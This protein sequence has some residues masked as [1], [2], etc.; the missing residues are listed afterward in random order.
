MPSATLLDQSVRACARNFRGKAQWF[1][2]F[3]PVTKKR[4]VIQDVGDLPYETVRPILIKLEKASQL[5]RTSLLIVPSTFVLTTTQRDI[6]MASPQIIGHDNEIWMEFIKRDIDGWEGKNLDPGSPPNWYKLYENLQIECQKQM[7]D[8]TAALKAALQGIKSE[9]LNHRS[10]QVAASTVPPLP[11]MGGMKLIK[12]PRKKRIVLVDD[13]PKNELMIGSRTKAVTGK[14]VIDKARR[15]AKVQTLLRDPTTLAVPTHKLDNTLSVVRQAP[16]SLLYGYQHPLVPEPLDPT[17]KPTPVFVPKR[18]RVEPTEL[19]TPVQITTNTGKT[20]STNSTPSTGSSSM[21]TEERER[22]LRA[23]TN[24]NKST[25]SP[26]AGPAPISTE[27]GEQKPKAWKIPQKTS[28]T[29]PVRRI[30]EKMRPS[31]ERQKRIAARAALPPRRPTP[32]PP[33]PDPWASTFQLPPVK[34]SNIGLQNLRPMK[35]KAPVDVFMPV[36]RRRLS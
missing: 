10:R 27:E 23:L 33:P 34:P 35:A 13:R 19:T 31:T 1:S 6:E 16:R 26:L 14:G 20:T 24:P 30:K 28:P 21:S 2:Q 8:D 4:S 32:P 17:N 22:R 3:E 15:E 36:K 18:K 25:S 7:E 29:P 5:V 9:S 12:T 11:K